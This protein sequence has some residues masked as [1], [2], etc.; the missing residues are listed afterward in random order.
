MASKNIILISVDALRWDHLS[1]F[2]YENISTPAI[3]EI[4]AGGVLYENC[5]TASC[6]TPVS[7][8]SVL[9]AKYPNKHGLSNPFKKI[10]TTS[11]TEIIKAKGYRTAGFTGINFLSRRCNFHKGFDSFK[12]PQEGWH[13]KKYKGAKGEELVTNWGYWWVPEYLDWIEKNLDSNFFIWGHYFECHVHAEEWLLSEGKIKSGELSEN[14]YY[15]AKIKYMDENLFRPLLELL[16]RKGIFEDT[17]IVI[18]SD[19][20]ETFNEHPHKEE[21][22]QHRTM[23]NSDLRSTLIIRD[24]LAT[25]KKVKN[26]V[27]TIDVAP[28]I[29][30]Q[31]FHEKIPDADGKSLVD[32]ND[33]D[34][35]AYS[36][37]MYEKRGAGSLQAIQDGNCKLIRNNTLN[38]EEFY[39]LTADYMEKNNIINE[40]GKS[41]VA[42]AFRKEL[43]RLKENRISEKEIVGD[44]EAIIIERLK[45]L[46]YIE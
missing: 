33:E 3:D 14:W 22:P 10:Q 38:T 36:E 29:L 18:M 15:D 25:G 32:L 9:T 37:E 2:G 40:R 39:D 12:E 41:E 19:H 7:M 43:D 28:T 35:I 17:M 6:L 1:C 5:M 46:G 20:G 26:L 8:A 42:C 44:E 13:H 4:A 21:Y 31:I 34:R 45:N 24:G 27:R 23:Y 30:E 16:K 11:M